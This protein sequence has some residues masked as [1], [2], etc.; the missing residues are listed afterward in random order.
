[1]RVLL[2]QPPYHPLSAVVSQSR[3]LA[4]ISDS[5][6]EVMIQAW[7][8]SGN[9]SWDKMAMGHKLCHY[10]SCTVVP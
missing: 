5:D 3:G 6:D 4:E 9:R 7:T 1:M 2:G 8:T 10:Y